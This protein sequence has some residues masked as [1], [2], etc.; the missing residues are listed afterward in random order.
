MAGKITGR[1]VVLLGTQV[2]MML[3]KRDQLQAEQH[4]QEKIQHAAQ[5]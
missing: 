2:M 5:A 1:A 3:G 4:S